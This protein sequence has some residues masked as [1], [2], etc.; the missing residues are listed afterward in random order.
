MRAEGEGERERERER[1]KHSK[2][3]AYRHRHDG[4]GAH[5]AGATRSTWIQS[6]EVCTS[7]NDDRV[8]ER[9]QS[10]PLEDEF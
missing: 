9:T 7:Q 5:L 6:I 3:D 2:T 8:T 10:R 1:E 4:Y